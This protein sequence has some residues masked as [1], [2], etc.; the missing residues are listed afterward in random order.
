MSVWINRPLFWS[1]YLYASTQAD[2]NRPGIS[3]KLRPN[4]KTLLFLNAIFEIVYKHRF[5]AVIITVVTL[6]TN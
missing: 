2:F 5:V 6:F 4:K 3:T 1:E